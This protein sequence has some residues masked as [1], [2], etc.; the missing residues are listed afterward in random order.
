M[1]NRCRTY[2]GIRC[3]PIKSNRNKKKCCECCTRD[4]VFNLFLITWFIFTILIMFGLLYTYIVTNRPEKRPIQIDPTTYAILAASAREGILT[5]GL[6]RNTLM[7]LEDLNQ[8]TVRR[9]YASKKLPAVS[10]R[11]LFELDNVITPNVVGDPITGRSLYVNNQ[12]G[13]N[14][15][16]QLTSRPVIG[17]I[18][19]NNNNVLADNRNNVF[20]ASPSTSDPYIATSNNQFLSM[21]QNAENSMRMSYMSKEVN[22]QQNRQNNVDN[23]ISNQISEEALLCR[24]DIPND[25]M[26]RNL[27]AAMN[28]NRVPESYTLNYK[29][30]SNLC[31]ARCNDELIVA[32]GEGICV[33]RDMPRLS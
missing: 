20:F 28:P 6:D 33:C 16:Q 29:V 26:N 22:V 11:E 1:D 17:S 19:D 8:E 30:K 31:N 3:K 4:V 18:N 5:N 7:L 27:W 2:P 32:P 23:F 24:I 9:L 15:R 10:A 13:V 25:C 12:A 21:D 14:N